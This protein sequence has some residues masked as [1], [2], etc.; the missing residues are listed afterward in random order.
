LSLALL[1]SELSKL[2]LGVAATDIYVRNVASE[3]V[4]Q[5]DAEPEVGHVADGVA[6]GLASGIAGDRCFGSIRNLAD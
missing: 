5:L 4:T 3:P 2:L 1:Q 6:Y